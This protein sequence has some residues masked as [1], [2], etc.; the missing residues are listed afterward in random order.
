ML[1]HRIQPFGRACPT[2]R[3]ACP[4]ARGAQ[5]CGRA[6]RTTSVLVHASSKA[7]SILAKA[8]AKYEEGDRLQAMK[9]YEDVMNED[10]TL[11]Q[12][13]ASLFGQTAVHASFGDVELAQMTLRE[14]LRIGLDF[15]KALE[16]PVNVQ[17]VTSP[18]ITIQLGRFAKQVQIAM[19]NRPPTERPYGSPSRRQGMKAQ[20]LDA[21]LGSAKGDT[22]E[23]DTSVGGI[24]R[25]VAI[26]LLVG[27]G[28]GVGLWF[29]GLEY[30]FPKDL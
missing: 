28:L 7:D 2:A 24:A 26:V 25:R 13:Q 9:L 27:V 21:I 3:P 23:V 14:A 15:Q 18:Q 8:K 17:M 11:E 19:A 4:V 12:K 22:A 30:L 1:A 6:T 29:L 5:R 16:D 10:P 20:D